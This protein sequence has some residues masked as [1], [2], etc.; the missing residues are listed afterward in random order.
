M[1]GGVAARAECQTRVKP[2]V[3]GGFV[4]RFVPCGRNPQAFG[5]LN[6]VELRLCQPHPVLFRQ[7]FHRV[8]GHGDACR[9][10]CRFQSSLHIGFVVK[11]GDDAALLPHLVQRHIGFAENRLLVV[12]AGK[13][14]FNGARQRAVFHQRIRI[15][16]GKGFGQGDVGLLVRH[17][18]VGK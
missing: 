9:L 8:F 3:D 10:G 2:Q 12:G 18:G 7:Y 14:V 1:R 15:G 5:N 6:R 4:G 13:R 17:N 16:F 11:Q